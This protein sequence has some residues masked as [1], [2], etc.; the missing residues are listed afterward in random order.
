MIKL[1]KEFKWER[2][3]KAFR[4]HQLLFMKFLRLTISE[5]EFLPPPPTSSSIITITNYK[6]MM[7]RIA[8][9]CCSNVLNWKREQKKTQIHGYCFWRACTLAYFKL[10]NS[11]LVA[12]IDATMSIHI[13]SVTICGRAYCRPNLCWRLRVCKCLNK[14]NYIPRYIQNEY[15]YFCFGAIFSLRCET[16]MYQ[17]PKKGRRW[18]ADFSRTWC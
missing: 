18:F 4:W 6:M 1:F 5:L 11:L 14:W 8:Y 7:I 13:V 9:C 15:C 12:F 16:T 10:L 17:G 2:N 3:R